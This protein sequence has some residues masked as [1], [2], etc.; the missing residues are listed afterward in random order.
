ML[1][2][3]WNIEPTVIKKANQYISFKI[4]VIQL[5]DILKFLGGATGLDSFLKVYKTSETK[6]FSPT[7]GLITLT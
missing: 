6:G 7:N 2:N 4:A 3:E 5:L 1:V